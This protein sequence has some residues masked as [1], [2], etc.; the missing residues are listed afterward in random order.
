[1]LTAG[2]DAAPALRDVLAACLA[3][4]E[5]EPNL[6]G[7]PRMRCAAVVL[8]DGLGAAALAAR[9]G[10]ARTLA[11][12][13]AE[14]R[15]LASGFPTTTAAALTSLTTGTDPGEHGVVGYSALDPASGEVVNQLRGFDATLPPGWQRSP[16]LFERARTVGV[17]PVAVG[18][19]HYATSGFT[20]AV[21]RGADYLGART[22]E[23]R[24]EALAEA[25]RRG[26][27][28]GY[29]Y[30]PE[31]DVAAHAEGWGSTRWTAELE[32]FEAALTDGLRLLGR[33]VGLVVTADHGM[34]DVARDDHVLYDTVPGLLDP[35]RAVAG[36]PRCLQLHLEQ[37]A[38]PIAVAAAWTAALGGRAT[39]VTRAEAVER[40]WFGQ[41]DAAV[42]PRIG[43]VLVAARGRV[44]L[45]DS[46]NERGRGMVGQH[47]SWE[48]EE[49]LVPLARFGAAA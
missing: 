20:G 41:V 6:I 14:G 16:T 23:A 1:M 31:L 3:A 25:F 33:D 26:R 13:A 11:G 7:L 39:V 49:R 46:R 10:H 29:L 18:P 21:L 48:D 30:V 44:A 28:V 34:V 36:E 43:D 47:G 42:L 8:V 17:R 40:G 15:P 22:M 45:Y 38:D 27:S 2:S 5:G 4:V 32:T 35:V 37:G 24:F 9:A 12:R 19:R